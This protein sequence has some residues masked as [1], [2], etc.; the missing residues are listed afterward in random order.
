MS[1]ILIID[2]IK[3]VMKKGNL[4]KTQTEAVPGYL[5][6]MLIYVTYEIITDPTADS[7]Y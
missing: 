1:L 2:E 5:I 4:L 6:R 3:I 7:S